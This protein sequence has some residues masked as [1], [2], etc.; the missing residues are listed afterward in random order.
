MRLFLGLILAAAVGVPADAALV[1]FS[2]NLNGANQNP[3]NSSPATGSAIL[4]LDTDANTYSVN[5][6]VFNM[7]PASLVDVGP[8]SPVHIHLGGPTTNG[9]VLNDLGAPGNTTRTDFNSFGFVYSGSGIA[10]DDQTVDALLADITYINV[11]TADFPSGEIRGQLM[12]ASAGPPTAV[13]EPAAGLALGLAAVG[14]VA[15]RIRR[16]RNITQA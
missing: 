11:H 10:V 5:L 1:N 13:P 6:S 7:D 16:R 2:A 14:F 12:S 9:M 4:T 3:S 8:F 15:V